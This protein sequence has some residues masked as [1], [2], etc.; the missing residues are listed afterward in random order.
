M[1]DEMMSDKPASKGKFFHARI[2]PLKF[3]KLKQGN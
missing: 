1:F 3:E 2:K